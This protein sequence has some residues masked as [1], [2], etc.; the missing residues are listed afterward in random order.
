MSGVFGGRRLIHIM[1]YEVMATVS[2]SKFLGIPTRVLVGSKLIYRP[3]DR[4]NGN[5]LSTNSAHSFG[6]YWRDSQ[7][8]RWS[9]FTV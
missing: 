7:V 4:A 5:A 2:V 9:K 6:Q 3:T 1:N 8:K